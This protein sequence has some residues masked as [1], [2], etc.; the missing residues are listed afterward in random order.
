M[1]AAELA[2]AVNPPDRRTQGKY[3]MRAHAYVRTGARTACLLQPIE[4]VERGP[5]EWKTAMET[6]RL[7]VGC[8]YPY[9]LM[10]VARM[11]GGVCALF[12]RGGAA[13]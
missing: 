4:P 5:T 2:A 6:A 3:T 11:P 9:V 12:E 13:P 8:P 10:R 7:P 1:R